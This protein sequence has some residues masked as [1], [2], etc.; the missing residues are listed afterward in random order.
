MIDKRHIRKFLARFSSS[1]ATVSVDEYLVEF[2]KPDGGQGRVAI[3]AQ[4]VHLP[5]RG[6]HVGHTVPI[7]VNR[8]G[9]QAVFGRFEPVVSRAEQRRRK[10]ERLA[11]DEARFEEKL[12]EN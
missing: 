7:H 10:R 9:T 11:K 5:V 3:K 12:R 4:S 6:V 8:K 2:P 1:I